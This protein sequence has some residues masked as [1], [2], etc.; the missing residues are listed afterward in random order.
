MVKLGTSQSLPNML[1]SLQLA[2]EGGE[3][4]GHEDNGHDRGPAGSTGAS[5]S[6]DIGP[7]AMCKWYSWA[8]P[9]SEEVGLLC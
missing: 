2:P 6:G 8:P 1:Q 9:A 7:S 3:D 4:N 5:G